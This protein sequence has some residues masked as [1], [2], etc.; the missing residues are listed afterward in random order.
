MNYFAICLFNFTTLAASQIFD[1]LYIYYQKYFLNFVIISSLTQ[2]LLRHSL[3]FFSKDFF[4][5]IYIIICYTIK[6]VFPHNSVGQESTCNVG[7]PGLIP[8][9]GRSPREG[10]GYPLQYSGLGNSMNHTLHGVAKS[11]T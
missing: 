8:G 2:V 10:K 11:W 4:V 7:D 3:I 6:R 5:F 9:S 1:T